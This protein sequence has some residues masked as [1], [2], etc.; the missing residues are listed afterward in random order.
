M[1]VVEYFPV[2][3]VLPGWDPGFSDREDGITNTDRSL[4][5]NVRKSVEQ[6]STSRVHGGMFSRAAKLWFQRLGVM[7]SEEDS[8]SL[9]VPTPLTTTLLIG[10]LTLTL[11]L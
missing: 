1:T 10:Q 4:H 9:Y 5:G 11:C 8:A 7:M 3:Y 2:V 6:F